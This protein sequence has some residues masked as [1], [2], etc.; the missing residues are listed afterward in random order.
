MSVQE[1]LEVP[2]LPDCPCCGKPDGRPNYDGRCEDCY[3]AGLHSISKHDKRIS[4]RRP[5]MLGSRQDASHRGASNPTYHLR[6]G[7]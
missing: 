6:G 4:L 7:G 1:E 2:D 3:I 5:K